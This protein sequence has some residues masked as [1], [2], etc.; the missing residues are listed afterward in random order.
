VPG[1][2]AQSKYTSLYK[3]RARAGGRY[4]S[5]L[6]FDQSGNL[7]GTTSEGGAHGFGTV[8]KLTPNSDGSWTESVLYS[9]TRGR[10]DGQNPYAG[11]TFDAAGNLYGT[12]VYG[13]GS[14]KCTDGCG[15]VFKLKMNLDGSWTESV[16]YNFAGG[17]DGWGPEAGLI[18]DALGNLYGTTVRGGISGCKSSCGT[19]FELMPN[20]DG[21]WKEKVL[22]RFNR[23]D[24]SH[25]TAGLILDAT[26]ALYGTTFKGGEGCKLGCGV[27]FKLEPNSDGT[28]TEHVLHAFKAHPANGPVAGLIFDTAGSLYG[29]TFHGGPAD[30]GAMFKLIP[31][32]NGSWGYSVLHV[33]QGKLAAN[34]LGVVLD[35]A[36]NLYG[37]SQ[38]CDDRNECYGTVFELTP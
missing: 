23:Q 32:S 31:N 35:E 13:G 7:Y 34:P 18:F 11:L 33:F 19:A 6:I 27:V 15:T 20:P 1:A 5:G 36:G 14:T 10:H 8:F 17:E 24:G 9:F 38:D 2:G 25:P 3:F 22:H 28:W 16:L 12:T 21:S 4:P 37:T 26:G 30:E 29:T